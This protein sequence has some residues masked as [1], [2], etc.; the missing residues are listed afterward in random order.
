[1]A[2]GACDTATA[3]PRSAENTYALH[4]HC[5]CHRHTL[6]R[7]QHHQMRSLAQLTAYFAWMHED[8]SRR[9][10]QGVLRA[11]RETLRTAMETGA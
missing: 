6:T 11:S 9:C 1:M 10:L 8:Q 5:A 7:K 3:H 2:P 4:S